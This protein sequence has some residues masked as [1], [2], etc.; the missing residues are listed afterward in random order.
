MGL[1]GSHMLMSMLAQ[2]RSRVPRPRPQRPAAN[3]LPAPF[4]MCPPACLLQLNAAGVGVL[5]VGL[6]EAEKA[7]KFAE[8]LGFPQDILYAGELSW[9]Q[10]G[11]APRAKACMLP[12]QLPCCHGHYCRRCLAS[13]T[14]RQP[15]HL[16]ANAAALVGPACP[17]PFPIPA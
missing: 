11:I 5:A 10:R 2:P 4:P 16:P 12:R 1:A 9:R 15:Q 8:L 14:S 7:R 3:L 13:H 6:G 17:P